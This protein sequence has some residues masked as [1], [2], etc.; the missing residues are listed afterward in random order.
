MVIRAD[1]STVAAARVAAGVAESA[2]RKL[3][4]R[5]EADRIRQLFAVVILVDGIDAEAAADFGVAGTIRILMATAHIADAQASLK[6][7]STADELAMRGAASIFRRAVSELAAPARRTQP[8]PTITLPEVADR[9]RNG[10]H[11]DSDP[12]ATLPAVTDDKGGDLILV[13]RPVVAPVLIDIVPTVD[14]EDPMSPDLGG[15]S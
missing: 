13:T 14:D 12:P 8:I 7:A 11:R 15:E 5:A 10:K 4:N 1:A 2:L 3:G 6:A 9:L